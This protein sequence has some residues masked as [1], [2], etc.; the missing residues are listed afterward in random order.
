M[1]TGARVLG[2]ALPRSYRYRFCGPSRRNDAMARHKW[3]DTP[4]TRANGHTDGY[5]TQHCDT[6][7]YY[8]QHCVILMD[9]TH[10]TVHCMILMILHTTLCTV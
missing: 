3:H 10:N 5:Y 7:G 8:T 6:D 1:V 9:T 2:A 4:V